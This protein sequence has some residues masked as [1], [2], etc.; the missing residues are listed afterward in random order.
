MPIPE[1]EEAFHET[2][3]RREP[4]LAQSEGFARTGTV[5]DVESNQN[6]AQPHF[7]V[8]AAE[9]FP[10]THTEY[11]PSSARTEPVSEVQ[12]IEP[13]NAF[14]E[15]ICGSFEKEVALSTKTSYET[16]PPLHVQRTEGEAGFKIQVHEPTALP[17]CH[18]EYAEIDSTEGSVS[19]ASVRWRFSLFPDIV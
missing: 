17:A 12:I 6:V 19:E 1:S 7:P 5:G 4:I 18:S 3:E 10:R 8:F 9:F 15:G 13:E 11:A 2:S 14:P 16:A